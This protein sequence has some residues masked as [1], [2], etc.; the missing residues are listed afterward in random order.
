MKHISA[1]A[2]AGILY[3]LTAPA[4]AQV[5]G[6]ATLGVTTTQMEAVIAGWSAKKDILGKTVYNDQKQKVGKVDDIVIAPDNSVSF[7]IIG[8]GGF[9]GIGKHDVA[10]PVEQIES[11]D[12]NLVLPGATKQALK[13]L[14]KF[15][16]T[17]KKSKK[18]AAAR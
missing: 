2:V 12:N 8:V 5:A 17:G 11:R 14:P 18:Q 15:E 1:A 6:K 9:V 3:L 7:A 13:D 10:I 16:Y 4:F